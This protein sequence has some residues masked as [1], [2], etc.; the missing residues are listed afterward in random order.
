MLVKFKVFG[1]EAPLTIK[2]EIIEFVGCTFMGPLEVVSSRC[3]LDG[4]LFREIPSD[5]LK[6]LDS[7]VTINLCEFRENGT[8]DVLLSQIYCEDAELYIKGGCISNSVNAQGIEALSSSITIEE[9]LIKANSGCAISAENSSVNLKN[10]TIDSNGTPAEEFSQIRL[11]GSSCTI[12]SCTL[13]EGVN[14]CGL[15]VAAGSNAN[16]SDSLILE[17]SKGAVR[18]QSGSVLNMRDVSILKNGDDEN[19]QIWVE[20]SSLD[21]FAV[22]IEGGSCA[23]YA[24]KAAQLQLKE[25]KI[26][27]NTGA[28][29]AFELSTLTLDRCYIYHNAS[30]QLWLEDSKAALIECLFS[31]NGTDIHAED[32]LQII[33]K[34]DSTPRL[35]LINSEI[36]YQPPD[37]SS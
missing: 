23:V 14:A 13:L 26:L 1:K 19:P 16:I 36:S 37:P 10:S 20:A 34:G 21:A 4:C 28:V 25:C 6:V 32:M 24:Q 33:I 5:A 27:N 30:S 29:C 8:G 18:V 2:N 7:N 3:R 15:S 31:G 35:E 22:K 17:H 9:V 11:S 12:D